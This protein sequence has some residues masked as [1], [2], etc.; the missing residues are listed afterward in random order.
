MTKTLTM[1]K[2]REAVDPLYWYWLK[3]SHEGCTNFTLEVPGG[4]KIVARIHDIVVDNRPRVWPA[5]GLPV[6]SVFRVEVEGE[7]T[8]NMPHDVAKLL[9]ALETTN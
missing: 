7:P 5:V 9:A 1:K 2:F 4:I 8:A 6:A 3:D